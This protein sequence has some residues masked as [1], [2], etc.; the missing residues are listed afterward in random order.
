MDITYCVITKVNTNH[1]EGEKICACLNI[2]NLW[3]KMFNQKSQSMW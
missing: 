2:K 3:Q 1:N